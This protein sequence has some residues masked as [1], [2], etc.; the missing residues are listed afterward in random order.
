MT[1]ALIV[2]ADSHVHPGLIA[3]AVALAAERAAHVS[4]LLPAVLPP[5]LPISAFPPRIAARM[6]AL[7]E[8]AR[9]ALEALGIRGRVATVP[10]RSVAALLHAAGPADLLVL[11]G[12]P[13]W[14]VRRAAHG[15]APAILTVPAPAAPRRARR[16]R[17]QHPI[18][19][20]EL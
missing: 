3:D 10:C 9:V 17:A 19:V 16:R 2:P 18:P 1:R 6:A 7:A 14:D 15:V 13:G 11:V 5:T 4:V 8:A 12:R 20:E